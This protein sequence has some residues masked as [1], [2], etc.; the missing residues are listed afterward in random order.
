MH[1]CYGHQLTARFNEAAASN[2]GKRHGGAT[3][4]Q[5]REPASMRP[6]HQTAEN[7]PM[8]SRPAPPR[9]GFNEAA[10]SNRGKPG[11]HE[12]GP[13]G[14]TRF[15]EAAASNRGKLGHRSQVRIAPELA[16]MRP[17]HQTAE[18]CCWWRRGASPVCRA[19]MRPRHQTAENRDVRVEEVGV[20]AHASMRP[21]HQTAENIAPQSQS[22]RA[23]R[24][25]MRPRH[26]TAENTGFMRTSV[27]FKAVLQ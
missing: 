26:Q 14:P 2:R 16:S 22:V 12:R 13:A 19:S 15:N 23:A 5:P 3:R 20:R 27:T 6:R 17:R 7:G 4:P 8:A 25:S 24:A 21:R 18:N 10:A 11:T 9:P 1:I